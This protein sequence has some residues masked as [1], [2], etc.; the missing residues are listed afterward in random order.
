MYRKILVPLDGSE[1]SERILFKLDPFMGNGR[2][3]HLLRVVFVY[4]ISEADQTEAEVL[5]VAEAEKYLKDLEKRLCEKGMRVE[6]HVRYGHAATEILEHA[7]RGNFDLIA[8]ANHGF[9][10]TGISRWVM[11]SVAEKVICSAKTPV[12]IS[13]EVSP[14]RIRE[15]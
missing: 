4:K 15:G 3:I 14:R 7:E 6:S 5:T 13:P 2:E 1:I 8:M 11:G 10:G 9:S 12:L